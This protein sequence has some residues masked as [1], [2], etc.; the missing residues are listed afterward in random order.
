MLNVSFYHY[1][2]VVLYC[3]KFD[4]TSIHYQMENCIGH[5]LVTLCLHFIVTFREG[6]TWTCTWILLYNQPWLPL[7]SPGISLRCTLFPLIYTNR[8]VNVHHITVFSPKHMHVHCLH[9]EAQ[10]NKQ[11]YMYYVRFLLPCVSPS[12]ILVNKFT[13]MLKPPGTYFFW[14]IWLTCPH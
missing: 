13:E 3:V 5:V 11:R 9:I 14:G 10:M 2:I 8:H 7:P 12:Y 6:S 4:C 1:K